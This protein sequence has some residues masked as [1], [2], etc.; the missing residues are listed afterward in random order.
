MACCAPYGPSN[1]ACGVV[2]VSS[3]L[4]LIIPQCVKICINP[5]SSDLGRAVLA[6]LGKDVALI[7]GDEIPGQSHCP[8]LTL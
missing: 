5:V 7:K 3:T 1:V 4:H 6:V 2:V 8:G